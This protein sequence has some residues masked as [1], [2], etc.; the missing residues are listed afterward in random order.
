M[1]RRK[2]ITSKR[3]DAI[4]LVVKS[5]ELVEAK[6][7]FDVWEERFFRSLVTMISKMDEDDKI[8]RVWFKD[9]KKN[10]RLKSNQSYDL[11]RKAARS[12]NKKPVYI[13]WTKDEFRRGREYNLFAFVDYLEEGQ[14]G[15]GIE[16]QEYVDVKIHQEM[17]PFLLYVKKNFDPAETRYTSYDLRNIEKLKPYSMRFYELFKQEEYKGWRTIRIDILKD[18]FLITDEYPRFSTLYQRVI[19]ASV[20]AINKFT[21]LT[22]PIDEIEKIKEGRKVVA[23]RFPIRSK[24]SKEIAVIRG[25]PIQG[26]LFE[27]IADEQV[28]EVEEIEETDAD[29][30]FNQFEETVTSFG[31]TPSV[32]I[33]MLNSGKYSKADIEQAIRVTRRAKFSQSIT[34]SI[35]GF[36]IKALKNKY[37]DEKEAIEKKKQ[38]KKEKDAKKATL[39]IELDAIKDEFSLKVN[40]RIKEITATDETV[41]NQAI[42]AIKKNILTSVIIRAKEKELNRPLEIEDFRQD[43][44]LRTLVISNIVKLEER[45][46]KDILDHYQGQIEQLELQITKLK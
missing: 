8:Y 28:T 37:I 22:I 36:F 42:Q 19:I 34:K 41:T 32:F 46:F 3:G 25:E 16:K 15:K 33:K 11:L 40:E 14:S 45:R 26:T 10:F 43:K 17:L 24:S 12:L 1:A 2:K 39:K 38:L 21:D 20:K 9:I 18:M 5:N 29:R 13:G 4:K 35:S 31:V 23:L 6:Y 44:Q 7:M 27:G 30:L